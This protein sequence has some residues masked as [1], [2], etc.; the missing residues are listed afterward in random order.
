MDTK[1]DLD[2]LLNSLNPRGFREK[3]LRESLVESYDLIV[4]G[5]ENNPFKMENKQRREEM[6]QVPKVS[7]NQTV[8]KSLYKTMED[9]IE[10]S[11]RDQILDLEDRIWQGGLGVLKVDDVTT[12]R[13][14]VEN[15]IYDFL[16]GHRNV[17]KR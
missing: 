1:E 15:G 3:Y 16:P 7:R 4:K 9:F 13:K 8:D 6:K 17:S 11:V 5:L 10:A 2:L 14:Q 12:W